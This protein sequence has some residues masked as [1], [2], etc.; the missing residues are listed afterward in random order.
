MNR[1]FSRLRRR[2]SF[3]NVTSAAAL[4][5][6]L[7]GTSYA[8]ITLPTN[9]VGTREIR[10]GG[11]RKAEIATG[12]VGQAEIRTGAV[13]KGEIKTG[14][15]GASE[16]H[17]D[18]VRKPEIK[19]DAVGPEEIAKDAVTADEIKDDSVGMAEL[20]D[21]TKGAITGFGV[22]STR[23]GAGTAG[24]AKTVARTGPGTYTVD[25]GSDVSK[26]VATASAATVKSGTTTDA[27]DPGA[28]A[29]S[30]PGAAATAVVV[31][32]FDTAGAPADEPFAL[33]LS[34]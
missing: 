25:F 19:T 29:S 28:T 15:V 5:V 23:G 10:T 18:S 12:G 21:A 11:V 27:P 33:V 1:P 17:T 24:N 9:S 20:D 16:L 6:A 4:F 22:A 7:G 30:A 8:A 26:C 34:C 14:G 2:L 32:T 13:G 3:A 31:N